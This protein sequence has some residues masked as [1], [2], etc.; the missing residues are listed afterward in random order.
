MW[1]TVY[2]IDVCSCHEN[3][4]IPNII[5]VFIFLMQNVFSVCDFGVKR[6]LN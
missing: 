5:M 1:N 6:L 4:T 2:K 3:F